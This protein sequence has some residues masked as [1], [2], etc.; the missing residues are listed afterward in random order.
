MSPVS[1]IPIAVAGVVAFVAAGLFAFG[2]AADVRA[3]TTGAEAKSFTLYAVSTKRKFVNNTDDRARGE[4]KNPFGNY[5]GS[6]ATA[7]SDERAFGPFAGD[8]GV[9]LFAL[10]SDAKHTKQAG[11]AT[12]ICQYNFGHN[13]I[14]DASFELDG[15]ALVGKG[16]YNYDARKF[17]LAIV[18][19]TSAYRS[20]RGV[21]RIATLG[22]ATQ[23]P[24]VRSA[25]PMLQAQRLD[26][27]IG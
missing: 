6:F 8:E 18:G 22:L 5:T 9:Y 23:K 26:F 13:G 15:G 19:G 12:F 10:Y 1:R 17:R 20:L 27:A 11:S 14:C 21:V 25:V 16:A 24:P 2:D 7:P 4:G 3:S